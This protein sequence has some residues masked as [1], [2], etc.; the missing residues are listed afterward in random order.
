MHEIVR[1]LLPALGENYTDLISKERRGPHPWWSL[2]VF[3]IR[4]ICIHSLFVLGGPEDAGPSS[5]P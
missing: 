3:A 1:R 5:R 4:L 2:G